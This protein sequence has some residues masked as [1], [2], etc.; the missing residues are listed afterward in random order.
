MPEMTGNLANFTNDFG[1][2]VEIDILNGTNYQGKPERFCI[3]VDGRMTQNA[4]DA[5]GVIGWF[6]NASHYEE[7]QPL[8]LKFEYF[9]KEQ[10]GRGFV[11]YQ[12]SDEERKV[13][14]YDPHVMFAHQDA[15]SDDPATMEQ[16]EKDCKELTRLLNMFEIDAASLSR[17]ARL[18]RIRK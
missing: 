9:R 15:E 17:R 12:Q 6:A 13:G 5:K 7:A 10:M 16:V 14:Q 8:R 3:T 11:A 1:Q 2:N 18:C 4:I